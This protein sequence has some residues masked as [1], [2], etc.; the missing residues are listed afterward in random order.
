MTGVFLFFFVCV[1]LVYWSGTEK[2]EERWRRWSFV[3]LFLR[4]LVGWL[5]CFSCSVSCCTGS[6]AALPPITYHSFTL[7][8]SGAFRERLGANFFVFCCLF[9][10]VFSVFW[11]GGGLKKNKNKRQQQQQQKTKRERERERER[12]RKENN[13]HGLYNRSGEIKRRR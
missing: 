1:C 7:V 4:L 9:F 2:E 10:G 5:V 11:G 3:C 6:R 8:N 12:E 13:R